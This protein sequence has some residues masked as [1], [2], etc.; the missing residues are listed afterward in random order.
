MKVLFDCRYVRTGHHDGISRYTVGLVGELAR[1][2]PGVELLVSDERQLAALPD[3]PW[4]RVSAPTSIREPLVARQVRR[5]G[6]DVVFS[7]MQTMGSWGR[8]YALVLTLHD[9]IY[10]RNRTPPPEFALPIRLLWRLYHLAW[11]PQRVLLN[12]AD[13]VVTVSETTAGLIAAHR[14]TRRPVTV[15]P[16]APEPAPD[17]PR[18]PRTGALVYM[19]SFMPYK[20]VA[21]LASAMPSLPDHELHLMSRVPPEERARL[22]A[23]APGGRIVFHDGASDE[24]YR[25][26]LRGATALVSASR[27]EGFGIPLVEAMALGTPLVVSD[28]PVFREVGGDAAA[29]V[30]PDDVGGFARAVR[31]L[32]DPEVWDRRSAAARTRAQHYTWEASAR[33]LLALLERVTPAR[34]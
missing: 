4:H 24:T 12:R 28:I 26:V 32:D 19:G 11:W 8:D 9:L 16:N 6:A 5:I 29:Y 3:L 2:H 10:Y 34:P 7:P 33:I 17:L 14:L 18:L 22:P 15:V 27:D 31:E 1:L 21:T 13:A 20:N 23:L 30:E 25:D